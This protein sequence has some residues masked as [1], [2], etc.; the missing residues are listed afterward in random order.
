MCLIDFRQL[1]NH[2]EQ[3]QHLTIHKA[4]I[5]IIE[6]NHSFGSKIVTY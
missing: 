6:A 1:R 4:D 3:T 5:Q 2:H